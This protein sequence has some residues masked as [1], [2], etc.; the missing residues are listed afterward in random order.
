M[1][2]SL[3][4]GELPKGN[5]SNKREKRKLFERRGRVPV[6]EDELPESFFVPELQTPFEVESATLNDRINEYKGF[7]NER[8]R[9]SLEEL[10]YLLNKKERDLRLKELELQDREKKIQEIEQRLKIEREEA[11]RVSQLSEE[12]LSEEEKA[13]IQSYREGKIPSQKPHNPQGFGGLPSVND[14]SKIKGILIDRSKYQGQDEINLGEGN[15][16]LWN[17]SQKQYDHVQGIKPGLKYTFFAAEGSYPNSE[18]GYIGEHA[19][20]SQKWLQKQVWYEKPIQGKLDDGVG[21]AYQGKVPLNVLIDMLNSR[22]NPAHNL[23]DGRLVEGVDFRVAYK[24]WRYLYQH[25]TY[26]TD[27]HGDLYTVIDYQSSDS[28]GNPP[29]IRGGEDTTALERVKWK[30]ARKA[31]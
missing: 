26:Y 20:Y 19:F 8:I 7:Y 14:S 17:K 31:V 18:A 1:V 21:P 4:S 11:Q 29:P 12:V 9:N 2:E 22:L 10:R 6:S 13:L 25:G 3:P 5:P 27:E 24:N 30:R 28:K 23:S 15:Y 16:L